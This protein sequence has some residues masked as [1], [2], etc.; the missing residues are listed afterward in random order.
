[1][2]GTG[3][4]EKQNMTREIVAIEGIDDYAITEPDH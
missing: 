4:L 1:M 3:S 2:H